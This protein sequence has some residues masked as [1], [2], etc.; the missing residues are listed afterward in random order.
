MKT[1]II[2]PFIFVMVFSQGEP[3][4]YDPFIKYLPKKSFIV[5]ADGNV[6]KPKPLTAVSVFLN[7]VFIDGSWHKKGDTIR[8][9]KIVS[10]SPKTIKLKYKSKIKTLLV[11]GKSS[12]ILKIKDKK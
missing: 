3:Y 12:N 9:Y 2:L 10:I 5:S 11:G 6:T 7:K 4:G 8:G 1:L